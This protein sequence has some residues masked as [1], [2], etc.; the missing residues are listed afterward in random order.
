MSVRFRM[1]KLRNAAERL[2]EHMQRA[3]SGEIFIY[4]M[5]GLVLVS[6]FAMY[7]IESL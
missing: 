2:S 3:G 7:A 1:T 4:L 5:V 6:G